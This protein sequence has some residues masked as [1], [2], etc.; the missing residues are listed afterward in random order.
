MSAEQ[1]QSYVQKL[2]CAINSG[3]YIYILGSSSFNSIKNRLKQSFFCRLYGHE[4]SHPIAKW[5]LTIAH[6]NHQ[7]AHFFLLR[8]SFSEVTIVVS[9]F[10]R[11][12][13]VGYCYEIEPFAVTLG[14]HSSVVVFVK[15]IVDICSLFG[16]V[17]SYWFGPYKKM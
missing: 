15:V 11:Y 13:V 5:C 2:L 7:Q 12:K 10:F 17:F 9:F 6:S 16:I 3:L 4:K 14:H 1:V 8:I